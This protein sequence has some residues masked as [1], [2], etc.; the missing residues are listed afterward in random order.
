MQGLL[1]GHHW[2]LRSRSDRPIQ[3]SLLALWSKF[4]Y[5]ALRRPLGKAC[6]TNLST[7]KFKPTRYLSGDEPRYAYVTPLFLEIR[8]TDRDCRGRGPA[9]QLSGSG[10]KQR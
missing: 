5:T 1:L 7:T 4:Q 3:K 8:N 9:P 10:P 2:S 6:P